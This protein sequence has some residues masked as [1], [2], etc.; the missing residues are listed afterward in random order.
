MNPNVHESLDAGRVA[1][2]FKALIQNAFDVIKVV[3]SNLK[4]IY[5]SPSIEKVLGYHPREILGTN[6]FDFIHPEDLDDALAHLAE[7]ERE[8]GSVVR[9]GMV[10]ARHKDGSWRQ[11]EV[12]VQNLVD[13]PA[14]QGV[15]MNY[16]DVTERE[17]AEVE[18]RALRERYEK[19]FR[20]SPDSITITY[21]DTGEMIET[22]EGFEAITG[23]TSDEVV[24][25][26]TLE[27]GIWKN[28]DARQ[29]LMDA[30]ARDGRVRDFDIEVHTKKGEP[31]ACLV[32]AEIIELG[33][34]PCVLAVTRDMTEY[35]RADERLRE[36]TEKLR[37]DHVETVRKNIALNEV[38]QHLEEGKSEYRRDLCMNIDN[39]FRP[40]LRRLH[41]QGRL[42][43]GEVDSLMR[44][45]DEI[46][47]EHIDQ[48]QNNV[49]KLTPR[50]LDILEMIRK[51]RPSKQI[52]ETLGLSPQTV[53]KHRQS[54][55]R[56]LQIDHREINLAAYLRSR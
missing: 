54:I 10:R 19:A 46:T 28:P 24:G 37:R 55:R 50:E 6:P 34:R 41:E 43:P 12:V 29:A 31:R 56:K 51:G 47:G 9:V 26:T 38:L 49:A 45:L 30:L 33:G 11:L 27:V 40:A 13:D 16:R 22:N 52:A 3:D 1:L 20:N 15:V 5:T 42:G 2:L 21:M 44:S 32:S 4:T 39:L 35:R 7:V 17:A 18:I 36:T 14:V 8:A 53:H 25:R 48:F 23:F